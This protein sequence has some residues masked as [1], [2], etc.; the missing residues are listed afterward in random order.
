MLA[1]WSALQWVFA[2]ALVA[3]LGVSGLIALYIAAR[4]F[5]NP[6]RRPRA[7]AR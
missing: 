7:R 2:I 4:L 1:A 6:A 5:V 3:I